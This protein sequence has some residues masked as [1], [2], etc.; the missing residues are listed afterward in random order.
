MAS[1][2]RRQV[3]DKDGSRGGA[4]AVSPTDSYAMVSRIRATE[5]RLQQYIADHGFG[6]FWHPGLGQEATQAGAV[7]ALR[8][9]DYLYYAHRG[10]GYALAKGMKLETLLAE[11]LGLPGRHVARVAARST[12]PT[13][14]SG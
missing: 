8:A 7:A 6:G 9:D 3:V 11:P 13:R 12:S 5:L 2:D 1:A 14:T 10:L 4:S